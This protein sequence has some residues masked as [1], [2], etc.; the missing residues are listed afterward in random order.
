MSDTP[1]VDAALSNGYAGAPVLDLARQL[2]RELAERT[3]VAMDYARSFDECSKQRDEAR[4]YFR[5]FNA[6]NH[7]LAT[8]GETNAK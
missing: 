6:R 1:R 4:V 7:G 8:Q 3:H 5:T 2:E